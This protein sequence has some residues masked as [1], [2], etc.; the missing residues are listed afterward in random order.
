[1]SK[2]ETRKKDEAV[3]VL[4]NLLIVELAKAGVQQSDIRRIVSVDMARVN[5][6]ARFFKKKR[7]RSQTD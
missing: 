7:M 4:K 5:N 6:I 2:R 3:E 1:M